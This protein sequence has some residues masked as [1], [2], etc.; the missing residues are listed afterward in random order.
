M[1]SFR[2]NN[3]TDL[4]EIAKKI[5]SIISHPIVCFY[6]EMGS[7]KTTLI[8]EILTH[9]KIIQPITSPTF[10][11]INTYTST[12]GEVF[13]HFDLYRIESETDAFN[14]GLEEYIDSKKY[15][16][17]EWP[18]KIESFLPKEYHK[19]Y[20]KLENQTRNITFES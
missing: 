11:L 3:L 10:S 8:K 19:I 20:I 5:S 6:G 12:V 17:I 18:E 7:G 15:C 14:I 16:F 2:A 1:L 13:Y 4:I 9:L